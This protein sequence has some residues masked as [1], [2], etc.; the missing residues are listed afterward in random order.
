VGFG[1]SAPEMLVSGI[2]AATGAGGISV[3]NA[4]GSNITNAGLVIGAAA[5]AAPLAVHSKIIRRELPLLLLIMILS[6]ALVYN[7]ELSR[8]DGA[9]LLSGFVLLLAWMA[10]QGI[11]D[12]RNG[13]DAEDA[14]EREFRQE[15]PPAMST[16]RALAWLLI[17][18]LV[19]LGSARV[20]VWGGV[21]IAQFF[22]VD[23]LVIGLT[24]VAI[25]TSLPEL[26]ASVVSARKGEHDIAIGNVIGSNMF[27]LLGVLA[28]PGIIA[29]GPLP[30]EIIT[31]D[32]PVM[33]GLTVLL[34]VLARGF[35]ERSRVTRPDGVLLVACYV[36]YVAWLVISAGPARGV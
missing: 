13:A 5:L 35:R 36:V 34:L 26:A 19:L 11:R 14:L 6:F 33:F 12:H 23:D 30:Q 15:Q 17:G 24:V 25:G 10:A 16:S 18:L 32:Y 27:N 2:A 9:I 4:I 21:A 7:G 22:G 20:V 1:T 3:G 28:L 29:P 31:R 8:V